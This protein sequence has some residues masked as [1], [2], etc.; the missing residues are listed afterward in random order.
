MAAELELE[1]SIHRERVG[2]ASPSKRLIPVAAPV[3]AGREK[4]YVADCMESG[5]ISSA[6][7]YVELFEAEFA[8][9]IR[10]GFFERF[11]YERGTVII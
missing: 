4:E 6:G 11:G 3:L 9:Y 2:D 1:A 5:W 7:K 8:T 10:A